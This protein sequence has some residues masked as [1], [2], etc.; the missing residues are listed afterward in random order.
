MNHAARGKIR[1][2]QISLLMALNSIVPIGWRWSEPR[3]V[4]AIFAVFSQAQVVL[5][6]GSGQKHRRTCLTR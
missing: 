3:R 2:A 1:S 6:L 5:Q 4:V